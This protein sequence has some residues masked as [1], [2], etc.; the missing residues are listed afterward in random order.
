MSKIK[1]DDGKGLVVPKNYETSLYG[2]F[3]PEFAE[4]LVN[5]TA[6]LIYNGVSEAEVETKLKE[7]LDKK[8]LAYEQT[9]IDEIIRQGSYIAPKMPLLIDAKIVEGSVC[10]L[11][12]KDSPYR[13]DNLFSRSRNLRL[14]NRISKMTMRPLGWIEEIKDQMLEYHYIPCF[15]EGETSIF[16]LLEWR[17]LSKD[18]MKVLFS[19]FEIVINKKPIS[20]SEKQCIMA[21]SGDGIPTTCFKIDKNPR[22]IEEDDNGKITLNSFKGFPYSYRK[23]IFV[24]SRMRRFAW[25]FYK[26]FVHYLIANKDTEVADK[27]TMFIAQAFQE[28]QIRPK[29]LLDLH[30]GEGTGKGWLFEC[31]LLSLCGKEIFKSESDPS[32]GSSVESNTFLKDSLFLRLSE[33][34]IKKIGPS[35]KEMITGEHIE[36]KRKYVTGTKNISP[37]TRIIADTNDVKSIDIKNLGTT[38]V[39]AV[40]CVDVETNEKLKSKEQIRYYSLAFRM[41]K[42]DWF[43]KA[44]FDELMEYDIKSFNRG[45]APH[46]EELDRQIELNDD[47]LNDFIIE[48]SQDDNIPKYVAKKGLWVKFSDLFEKYT[49]TGG[50]RLSMKGFRTWLNE[51]KIVVDKIRNKDKIFNAVKIPNV[52]TLGNE[53]AISTLDS[54]HDV[55]DESQEKTL[56]DCDV[57]TSN[58]SSNEIED[59]NSSLALFSHLLSLC[60]NVDTFSSKNDEGDIN[61]VLPTCTTSKS[62]SPNNVATSN[63]SKS[64]LPSISSSSILMRESAKGG[65]LA[66]LPKAELEAAEKARS[67]SKLK[68]ENEV[69]IF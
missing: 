13:G 18:E 2:S 50:S 65:L 16:D 40:K 4:R 28:P 44:I 24:S 37:I 26:N 9:T 25:N 36:I 63:I 8:E 21:W 31:L 30:S 57:A 19:Q 12:G 68:D 62:T 17:I 6:E 3:S 55:F 66:G 61:T 48:A 54:T 51:N 34:S 58:I 53:I 42:K 52:A 60:C 15:H 49:K 14:P 41:V 46:S 39:Y 5:K 7:Y 29:Y 43:L 56:L 45:R 20:I 27:V 67:K 32:K 35:L 69:E 10:G 47:G 64:S 33:G 38:R 23:D 11:I 22:L 59:K 1:D